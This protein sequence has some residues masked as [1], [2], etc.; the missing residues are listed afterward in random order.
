[1]PRLNA[2]GVYKLTI[3]S[4]I[5]IKTIIRTGIC[6]RWKKKETNT[7]NNN[8]VLFC[9]HGNTF[10]HN[11]N[12]FFLSQKLLYINNEPC[13][14]KTFFFAKLHTTKAKISRVTLQTDQHLCCALPRL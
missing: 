9:S 6:G 2:S 10:V 12:D 3:F 1:M 8:K 13:H 7:N 5:Y 14:E 4:S 11:Q